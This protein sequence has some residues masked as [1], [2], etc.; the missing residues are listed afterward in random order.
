MLLV[1]AL[2]PWL[3]GCGC[4]DLDCSDQTRVQ[5]RGNGDADLVVQWAF[6]FGGQTTCQVRSGALSCDRDGAPAFLVG[7][8]IRN[9]GA[10]PIRIGVVKAGLSARQTYPV[11]RT[12]KN[13]VNGEHY[14]PVCTIAFITVDVDDLTIS[15]VD[16]PHDAADAGAPAN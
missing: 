7:T 14:D 9:L 3:S 8:E 5:V 10:S 16:M 11:E 13:Y 12:E 15:R 2:V 4:T 6:G 1:T